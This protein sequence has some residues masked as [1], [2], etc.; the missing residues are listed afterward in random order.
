MG[1]GVILDGANTEQ[2]EGAGKPEKEGESL[3][4]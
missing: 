3:R 4:I 2:A 1:E